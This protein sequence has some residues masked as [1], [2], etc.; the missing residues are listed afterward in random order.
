MYGPRIISVDHELDMFGAPHARWTSL[1]NLDQPG[2][3]GRGQDVHSVS[4]T[5]PLK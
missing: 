5:Q 2:R 3:Y 1:L 4:D